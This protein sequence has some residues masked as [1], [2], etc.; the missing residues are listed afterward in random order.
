MSNSQASAPSRPV[1]A[2]PGPAGLLLSSIGLKTIMAVTGVI[3]VGFLIGHFIG[4]ALVFVGPEAINSYSAFL[5]NS[6]GLLWVARAVLLASVGLHIGAALRLYAMNTSARPQRYQVK[7]DSVTNYAART[8]MVTGP[9]LL[10]FIVFH[11]AHLTF[12][13]TMGD[14]DHSHTDVYSNVISSFSVPWVSFVYI[15]SMLALGN[16]LFHGTWSMFQ[17]L[18]FNHSAYNKRIMRVALG[19]TLFVTLGNIS[20]PLAV[21]FGIVR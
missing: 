10:G 11:L 15:I 5:H 1:V 2:H 21:L 12:G 18:G 4:N 13:V 14:Y 3:L 17:S 19:I 6:H 16:H 7:H 8:M 9:I 20:I